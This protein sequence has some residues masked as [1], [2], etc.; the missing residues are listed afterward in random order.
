MVSISN[1]SFGKRKMAEGTKS[2]VP[3]GNKIDLVRLARLIISL[4]HDN[5]PKYCLLTEF[6]MFENKY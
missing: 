6:K 4:L 2:E 3:F 1:C 5:W